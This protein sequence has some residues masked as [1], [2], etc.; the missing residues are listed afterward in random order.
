VAGNLG[1]QSIPILQVNRE[2]LEIVEMSTKPTLWT[3][4]IHGTLDLDLSG[5]PLDPRHAVVHVEF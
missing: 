2:R 1:G 5:G 4:D 3:D